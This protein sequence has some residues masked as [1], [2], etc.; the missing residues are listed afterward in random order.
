MISA[1]HRWVTLSFQRWFPVCHCWSVSSPRAGTW[2]I[3]AHK[4]RRRQWACTGCL[5][6]LAKTLA[7]HIFPCPKFACRYTHCCPFWNLHFSHNELN[8]ARGRIYSLGVSPWEGYEGA[9]AMSTK[10]DFKP[11]VSRDGGDAGLGH[12]SHSQ[13]SQPNLHRIQLV[14]PVRPGNAG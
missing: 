9:G 1:C 4:T 8:T 13:Q 7:G 2:L 11:E 10:Q 3:S 6:A 12:C 5:S 14:A